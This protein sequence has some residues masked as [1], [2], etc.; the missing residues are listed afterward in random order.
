M[1]FIRRV[2]GELGRFRLVDVA[3]P[4]V[5]TGVTGAVRCEDDEIAVRRDRGYQ[6]RTGVVGQALEFERL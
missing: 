5:E 4:D 1:P 2:I 3:D 6:R